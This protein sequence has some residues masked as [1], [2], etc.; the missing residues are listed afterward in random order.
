MS[1]WYQPRSAMLRGAAARFPGYSASGHYT[2]QRVRAPKSDKSKGLFGRTVERGKELTEFPLQDEC[3]EGVVDA[4]IRKSFS[5]DKIL[6]AFERQFQI[7]F[8]VREVALLGRDAGEIV[9]KAR[10]VRVFRNTVGEGLA[11]AAQVMR[12][13]IGGTEIVDQ[14]APEVLVQRGRAL[15]DFEGFLIERYGLAI[16]MRDEVAAAFLKEFQAVP[17]GNGC[18]AGFPGHEVDR[19]QKSIEEGL[20]GGFEE[21]F[22]NVEVHQNVVFDQAAKD[23]LLTR[24]HALEFRQCEFQ[25]LHLAALAIDDSSQ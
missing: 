4:G 15:L 23:I 1:P 11:G 5:G 10:I 12:D 22:G 20:I 7:I 9:V 3:L 24:R 21:N 19:L 2:A 8:S 14:H 18:V 25:Y 16:L 6:A 17:G 13:P